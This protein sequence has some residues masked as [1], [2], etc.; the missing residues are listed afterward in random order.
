MPIVGVLIGGVNL[1]DRYFEVLTV[2]IAWGKAF[3]A[4]F[5]FII[6]GTFLYFFLRA[7]GQNT[8]AITQVDDLLIE[9]RDEL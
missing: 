6:V 9:I 4:S 5:D 7:L 1:K 3:Q 2:K 8:E